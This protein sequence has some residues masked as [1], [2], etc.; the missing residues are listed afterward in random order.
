MSLNVS[1]RAAGLA[2]MRAARVSW[3]PKAPSGFMSRF[4]L[5]MLV[6][7]VLALVAGMVVLG[8]FPPTPARHPVSKVLPND[9]FGQH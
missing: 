5:I 9:S 3:Q 7:F 8:E 1:T 4:F 2:K 6:A